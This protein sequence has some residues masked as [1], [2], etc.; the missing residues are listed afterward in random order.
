M[1]IRNQSAIRIVK[2]SGTGAVF[3]A[4]PVPLTP[5]QILERQ[6]APLGSV[7]LFIDYLYQP[8]REDVEAAVRQTLRDKVYS[9]RLWDERNV[10][11]TFPKGTIFG[12]NHTTEPVSAMLHQRG[13]KNETLVGFDIRYERKFIGGR[14][15]VTTGAI[16]NIHLL[17][18]IPDTLDPQKNPPDPQKSLAPA[19]AQ[20]FEDLIAGLGSG[21]PVCVAQD[22]NGGSIGQATWALN[23]YLRRDIFKDPGTHGE[24]NGKFVYRPDSPGDERDERFYWADLYR[25]YQKNRTLTRYGFRAKRNSTTGRWDIFLDSAD[26][27]LPPSRGKRP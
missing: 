6:L 25:K 5:Q 22:T 4:A 3:G 14:G 27:L 11:V 10:L 1:G 12:D 19:D 8:R 24:V 17:A 7:P 23:Q 16:D 15:F 2:R 13:K 9:K 21:T 20:R 26:R 18:T